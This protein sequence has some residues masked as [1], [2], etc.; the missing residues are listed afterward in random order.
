MVYDLPAN[1]RERFR[2]LYDAL[3]E[4]RGWF[5]DAT[6]LR[7]ASLSALVCPGSPR[8]VA[9][10]IR[11]AAGEIKERS[12]WFGQLRSP[13]RFI[14]GATLLANRDR[15][16]GFLDEVDRV[17]PLFREEHIRRGGTYEVIAILILRVRGGVAPIA[18]ETIERF[19]AIY[20]E[21]KRYHWWL[22]GTADFPACALLAGEPEGPEAIGRAIE[23]I[24]RALHDAGF[25]TG[26][27]LQTAANILYLARRAPRDAARRYRDLAEGFRRAGVRIWRSD[28]DELAILTFL[29]APAQRLIDHVLEIRGEMETLRP[30]PNRSM[31][32]SLASGI[33]FLEILGRDP[34]SRALMDA[35]A[36]ADMEAV[37]RAQHAAAAGAAASC[38]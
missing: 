38:S 6:S 28:Y 3:A 2:E 10:G 37:L 18:T 11:A 29:D 31:T 17:R 27:P 25:A 22:T 14:L 20:D 16:Q 23:E 21:M 32:F 5:G 9:S 1:P 13:L 4:D 33:A 36:L 7:F 35:K 30:K 12:S 19:H 15:V 26:D 8:E 34:E 24:Y